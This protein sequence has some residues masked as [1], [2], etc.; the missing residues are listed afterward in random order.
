MSIC[1]QLDEDI[2]SAA[3]GLLASAMELSAAARDMY[4]HLASLYDDPLGANDCTDMFI[5]LL[6]SYLSL[7][8]DLGRG[9]IPIGPSPDLR[10]RVAGGGGRRRQQKAQGQEEEEEEADEGQD[11]KEEEDDG[12]SA[13]Q[14]LTELDLEELEQ[15]LDEMRRDV[16]WM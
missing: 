2:V 3:K 6:E 9:A 11:E 12:D 13:A 4:T 1:S 8:A 14:F 16:E 7:A 15:R 5:R 10:V